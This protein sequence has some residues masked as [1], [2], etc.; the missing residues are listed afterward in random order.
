MRAT[1]PR[2]LVRIRPTVELRH[3]AGA[4]SVA[5][6]AGVLQL[7][8]ELAEGL[9]GL[10]DAPLVWR[11]VD[12]LGRHD[13]VAQ[14]AVVNVVVRELEK[15]SAIEYGFTVAGRI[16]CVSPLSRVVE[17]HRSDKSCRLD[18]NR[19][20][21]FHSGKS[22]LASPLAQFVITDFPTEVLTAFA[23][24]W[25]RLDDAVRDECEQLFG[26][27]GFLRPED[28]GLLR[29]WDWHDLIFH[30]ATM[31][32]GDVAVRG[33]TYRG[34]GDPAIR[35][36]VASPRSS[37]VVRLPAPGGA[38]PKLTLIDAIESRRSCRSFTSET[39]SLSQISTL[40]HYVVGI[41]G[42]RE[43][44]GAEIVSG[45]TPSAGS[46]HEISFY[47]C[48][49]KVANLSPGIYFYNGLSHS[50]HFLA[51]SSQAAEASSESVRAAWGEGASSPSATMLFAARLPRLGWKYEGIAY[52][53]ALLDAGVLLQ[54]LYLVAGL[55]GLGGC[56]VG[57]GE[58][59]SLAG[60]TGREFH[61]ETV[62]LQFGFGIPAAQ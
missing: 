6:K 57:A 35:A 47:L 2:L 28:G 13:G 51:G 59:E 62:I 48:A 36:G 32:H 1:D 29:Y 39:I 20:V 44:E 8:D 58:S 41:R 40:L 25:E 55:A 30:R 38:V 16:C 49:M 42:L 19:Y 27:T 7:P 17:W 23:G 14:R 15:I 34:A 21:A 12:R 60:L 56:A 9:A 3:D 22:A 37:T 4:W 53:L 61:E 46:L 18:P 50:L 43:A 54:A 5:A 33:A 10:L 26:I 24:E 11:D 45:R 52:R 31:S